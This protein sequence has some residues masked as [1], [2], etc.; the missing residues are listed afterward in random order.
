MPGRAAS[1]RL[2]STT[3]APKVK[4]DK[5]QNNHVTLFGPPG[6]AVAS[7]PLPQRDETPGSATILTLTFS[8]CRWPI[9]DPAE[10]GFTLCGRRKEGTGP[11]CKEHAQVA[12][13]PDPSKA[14]RKRSPHIP[15]EVS[16]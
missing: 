16:A 5:T 4:R 6:A 7:A 13:R 10:T 8:M 2:P 9:G 12:Y 1:P 3:K 15:A 11:Y 14:K